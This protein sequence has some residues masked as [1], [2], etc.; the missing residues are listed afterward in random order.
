MLRDFY[1]Y[2]FREYKKLFKQNL[3]DV[4]YFANV[5]VS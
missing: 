2:N 4:I 1:Y 3:Q 5:T